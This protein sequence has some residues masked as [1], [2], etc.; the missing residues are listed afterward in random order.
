MSCSW[1]NFILFSF[2]KG[3]DNPYYFGTTNLWCMHKGKRGPP[4]RG[5]W[6]LKHRFIYYQGY[7][8]EFLGKNRLVVFHLSIFNIIDS[9]RA[10]I[11]KNYAFS[12]A[13]FLSSL[14]WVQCNAHNCNMYYTTE[15][16]HFHS[17]VYEKSF[18]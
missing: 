4:S 1:L 13:M 11:K 8:I 14:T 3:G 15:M 12:I 7:Y 5:I 17:E 18:Y 16:I 10:L 6:E 9:L 2:F